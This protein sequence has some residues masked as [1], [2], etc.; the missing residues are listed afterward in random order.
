MQSVPDQLQ[1]NSEM[2]AAVVFTYLIAAIA[3]IAIIYVSI[4]TA[5][6]WLLRVW[7]GL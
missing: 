5:N 7:A 6:R 2:D 3:T 4:Y 1:N